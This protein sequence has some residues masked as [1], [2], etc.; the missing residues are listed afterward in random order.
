MIKILIGKMNTQDPRSNILCKNF[1]KL[2][3]NNENCQYWHPKKEVLTEFEKYFTNNR[4]KKMPCV[5]YQNT[6]CVKN[7]KDCGYLHISQLDFMQLSKTFTSIEIFNTW[8]LKYDTIC[9]ANEAIRNY[10]QFFIKEKEKENDTQSLKRPRD[11]ENLDIQCEKKPRYDNDGYISLEFNTNEH[12]ERSI[13][14]FERRES[15]NL[16]LMDRLKQ[17]KSNKDSKNVPI[18]GG[19]VKI[20]EPVNNMNIERNNQQFAKIKYLLK[21]QK[22]Y[23]QLKLQFNESLSAIST[24][25]EKNDDY[26]NVY[27]ELNNILIRGHEIAPF[28]KNYIMNEK[29]ED[30]K[31]NNTISRLTTPNFP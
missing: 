10:R 18:G 25:H 9:A 11:D 7:N 23:E 12:N 3:C 31:I 17:I 30:V 14:T 26:D 27:N 16:R 28:I 5:Y 29:I 6:A 24:Y 21:F 4:T 22:M 1:I 15:I 19:S 13:S 8:K 2:T 20:E